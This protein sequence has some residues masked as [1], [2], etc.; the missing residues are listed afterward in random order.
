MWSVAGGA[1]A[2]AF[3]LS[4]GGELTFA[5]AKDFETPDDADADGVYELTVQ[6]SDGANETRAELAVTV[7]AEEG[8]NAPPA[9]VPAIAGTAQVG[10]VLTASADG[11]TDANGLAN[12]S[13]AW[14]WIAHDGTA[15]AAIAGATDATYVLTSAELGKTIKVRVAFTDD[16]GNAEALESAATAPVAPAALTAAFLDVPAR[17]DGAGAFTLRLLFSESFGLGYKVLRD[18]AFTVK[19]GRIVK[20]KRLDNPHRERDGLQ[21]NREWRL[22]VEPASDTDVTL[23]LPAT[24]DCAAAGAVCAGDG[25]MLSAGLEAT[26]PG[27]ATGRPEIT[28]RRGSARR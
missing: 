7:V 11:I 22:T 26:V 28:G 27:P 24:T 1:D 10:A 3:E 18:R 19:G 5:S 12:A 16:G 20:A 17:H 4:A 14:Q 15:D 2:A 21:A 6:V 8:S 13:F 25:R 23:T 9:G